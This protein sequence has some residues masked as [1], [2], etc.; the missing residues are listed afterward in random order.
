M[1][2]ILNLQDDSDEMLSDVSATELERERSAILQ[3]LTSD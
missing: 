1:A 2:L 3:K